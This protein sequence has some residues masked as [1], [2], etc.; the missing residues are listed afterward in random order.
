MS[1]R[2]YKGNSLS[3]NGWPICDRNE[4]EAYRVP[5]TNTDF[6]VRRGAP[7]LLLVAFGN[8]Y[9]ANVEPID[10]YRPTDDWGWSYENDVANSNHLSGTAI[11]INATQYPWGARVM[12]QWQLDRI[13]YGL[14]LFEG[15]IYWGNSWSRADQM[16]YQVWCSWDEAQSFLDRKCANGVYVGDK[17]PVAPVDD[18]NSAVWQEILAHKMGT[19]L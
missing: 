3:E 8:W 10:I 9:H 13:N 11:D 6:I 17:T 12:P 2:T 18:E 19:S 14:G 5:G 7:G 1:F 4:C 15:L 16:H